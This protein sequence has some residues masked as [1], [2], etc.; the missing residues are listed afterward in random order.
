M[1]RRV[2]ANISA[3]LE[4]GIVL[5]VGQRSGRITYG[6]VEKILT[7]SSMHPHGIKVR[8]VGGEVGRVKPRFRIRDCRALHKPLHCMHLRRNYRCT[9]GRTSSFLQLPTAQ[10][11]GR[12]QAILMRNLG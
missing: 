8:L 4:V 7:S 5:K 12:F 11:L 2:K 6:R 3:G 9:Y 10:A 1:D